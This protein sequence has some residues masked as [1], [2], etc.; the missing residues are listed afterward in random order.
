M[1][2]CVWVRVCVLVIVLARACMWLR[3]WVR[4]CG[5][6]CVGACVWV[7][8]CVFGCMC[9]S[10]CVHFA[11]YLFQLSHGTLESTRLSET[12]QN[13]NHVSKDTSTLTSAISSDTLQVKP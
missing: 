5:F 12:P 2:A 4:V 7:R 1:G 11:N 13:T 3:V 6:V 9:V 10:A 8:V